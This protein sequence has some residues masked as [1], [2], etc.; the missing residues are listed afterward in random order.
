MKE[1][2][3]KENHGGGGGGGHGG[4]GRGGG[5]Y[6]GRGWGRGGNWYGGSAAW[7]PYLSYPYAN[8][9]PE[10]ITVVTKQ[11][12]PENPKQNTDT[13]FMDIF[14][15]FIPVIVLLAFIILYLIIKK[16]I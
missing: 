5:G 6:G 16:L 10:H 8:Y 14:K 11:T 1:L 13:K 12:Q 7:S 15:Y 9:Y 2:F 3:V 4:G